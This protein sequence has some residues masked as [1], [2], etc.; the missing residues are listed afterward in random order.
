MIRRCDITFFKGRINT[1][2][3]MTNSD[4]LSVFPSTLFLSPDAFGNPGTPSTT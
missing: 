1:G 2:F 4:F 3:L